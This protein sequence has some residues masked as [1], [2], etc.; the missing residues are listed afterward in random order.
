M[1]VFC[2]ASLSPLL[3]P[4][5]VHT[6]LDAFLPPNT[7]FRFNPYMSEDISM[8]ENR[9]EKLKLLQAEGIRYLERN[10]EKLKKVA[11]ILTQEKTSVQ[12]TAEWAKLR[13]DMY[14]GLSFYSSKL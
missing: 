6:M 14:N 4:P 7:Y 2:A 8:D 9:H 10:E 3:L 13:A 1:F 11:R 5:E 12:R